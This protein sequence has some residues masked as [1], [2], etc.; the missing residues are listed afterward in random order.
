[1]KLRPVTTLNGERTYCGPSVIS[2][3]TGF[4]VAI[5]CEVI[6]RHRL[7]K[8]LGHTK[9][10][11][12]GTYFP[13]VNACLKHYGFEAVPTEMNVPLTHNGNKPTI[14]RWI[15]QRTDRNELNLIEA[16]N[17]WQLIKGV[18]F[19]DSFTKVPVFI[20]KAPHRCARV[21]RVWEIIRCG[22]RRIYRP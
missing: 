8:G 4:P 2:A 14:A 5:I 16:G 10:H 12:G 7:A 17:H 1:M 19:V 15:K 13:E 9:I 21:N 20:R 11:V 6:N 3:V 22:K 18:K